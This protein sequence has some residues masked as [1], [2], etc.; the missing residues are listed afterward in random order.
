MRA[1][2]LSV[3]VGPP[4]VWV[5]SHLD[6]TA[7][8]VSAVVASL[9]GA[10]LATREKARIDH[11]NRAHAHAEAAA[12]SARLASEAKIERAELEL[13]EER[14]RVVTWKQRAETLQQSLEEARSRRASFLATVSH[15]LRTPLH[16]IIGFNELVSDGSAGPVSATQQEYLGDA[17]AAAQHLMTLITDVLDYAKSDAGRLTFATDQVQVGPLVEEVSA[18]VDGLAAKKELRLTHFCDE[19]LTL[20]GDALRVKQV[21]LNLVANAVK[22]TPKRGSVELVA[23]AAGSVCELTVR[24]TGPGI[25]LE[26]QAHL[27]EP[28]HQADSSRA[29]RHSGT[30]LGL[31]LVKR[32]AEAMGGCVDLASQPGAGT[33]VTVS[34]PSQL[35]PSGLKRVEVRSRV[36]VLVA[37]DDDATRLMLARVLEAQGFDVRVAPNGQRALEAVM[38]SLPSVLI[39]DLM[40]PE[41]DGHDLLKKLRSLPAG[42]RVKVLVFSA[43]SPPPEL[44]D[45]LVLLDA[46]V[47]LKGALSTAELIQRV[48]AVAEA[49]RSA[50]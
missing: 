33:S 14:E 35:K 10:L 15:E 47:L 39:L 27:F 29:R 36:D 22:F 41:L 28:F 5:C 20:V 13:A 49:P 48:R 26:D 38:A 8:L 43:S 23:R 17:R 3:V 31:A 21:L 46:E 34:L 45:S 16:A 6:S 30:G 11:L 7:G 12:M 1:V 2:W 37:E 32:W 19:G 42:E 40:M 44:R 18:L 50:A 4:V 24:D 25:A 9:G